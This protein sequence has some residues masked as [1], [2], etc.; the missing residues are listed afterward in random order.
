[1]EVYVSANDFSKNI[2]ASR[3]STMTQNLSGSHLVIRYTYP[4]IF[5]L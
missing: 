2:V 5:L 1:M 4:A 3:L